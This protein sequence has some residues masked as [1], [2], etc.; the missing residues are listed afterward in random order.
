MHHSSHSE[1]V[2][3]SNRPERLNRREW[4]TFLPHL[5]AWNA[6]SCSRNGVHGLKRAFEQQH[7]VSFAELCIKDTVADM[8]PSGYPTKTSRSSYVRHVRFKRKMTIY[9]DV[10]PLLQ[11]L[12]DDCEDSK[13]VRKFHMES[14][15]LHLTGGSFVVLPIQ[16]VAIY[17]K[18]PTKSTVSNA[19]SS[20]N[21]VRSG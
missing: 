6:C 14:K 18:K 5:C 8:M 10:L 21:S 7:G 1:T 9:V 13:N 17:I 19:P 4:R 16:A 12:N 2:S 3:P 20:N 11:W 15:L